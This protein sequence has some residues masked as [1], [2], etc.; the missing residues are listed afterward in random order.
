MFD[1]KTLVAA[2]L[3]FIT[4]FGLQI[5]FR[6]W[7]DGKSGTVEQVHEVGASYKIPSAHD[8]SLPATKTIS[9][10]DAA[11]VSV[12]QEVTV[13]T[14]RYEAV[15]ST[16][17]GTLETLAFPEHTDAKGAPLQSMYEPGTPDQASFIL[18]INDE[19][20]LH[21]HYEGQETL[22]NG[23]V[24]VTYTA[25]TDEW[26]IRKTFV[27]HHEKYLIDLLIEL[28]AKAA[29]PNPIRPRLFIGAP[30]LP[31]LE[32]DV[33]SGV[34]LDPAKNII[35]QVSDSQRASD[36]WVLP[37]MIGVENS[38]FAHALIADKDGFAQRGYFTSTESSWIS[39]ILEGPA[40]IESASYNLS[41]FVGPK[42]LAALT[43]VDTR[44][45]GLLSFG[46]LSWFAKLLLQMLSWLYEL[47]HNYGLA[48]IALTFILK[49]ILLPL[50]LKSAGINEQQQKLQPRI[51]ALRKKYA[52]D[53]AGFNVEVMR[54]Y[55]E[56]GVSPASFMLG[57]LLMVPQML[58]FFAMYRA[59]GNVI[60]MYQAPFFG[61]IVDLSSKDPYYILPI[62]A[63]VAIFFQPM[64]MVSQK[65]D[66][67]AMIM[68]YLLPA[69]LA[70][71]FVRM[72]AGLLLF[73]I[74]N[75]VV[76][77]VEQ[78]LRKLFA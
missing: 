48:I 52:N 73:I 63:V 75:V 28:K 22:K 21:Y 49:L 74:T 24:T 2:F 45:E 27:L 34:I 77:M 1:K 42:S 35:N 9:F 39:A 25:R 7:F 66:N 72:P 61:W 51:A 65:G 47:C 44:L 70:T 54:L 10:G 23:D 40:I 41:F 76:T 69:I 18:A 43:A 32:R 12:S 46:W 16:Y 59:L 5:I 11:A 20:P 55:Q 17:G 57:C 14:P 36:A 33:V 31:A 68:R 3:S 29:H 64:G 53:T 60:D 62:A 6:D 56:H 71:V 38:Y 58:L 50:S 4:I 67:Q 30:H 78:K 13:S 26:A 15:F 19:T 37:Q 8:L